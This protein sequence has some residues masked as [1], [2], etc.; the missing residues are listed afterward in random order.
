M[1]LHTGCRIDPAVDFVLAQIVT[2]MGKRTIR[3]IEVLVARLDL[4]LVGMAVGTE[5]F[6]M[7]GGTGS[8][9]AGINLVFEHEVRGLVIKGAPR[10]GMALGTVRQTFNRFGVNPGDAGGVGASKEHT[11]CQ[12]HQD[13]Q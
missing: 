7:T 12:R 8:L 10:V 11:G 2:T 6:L 13:S 3:R 4:L 9:R 1:A 5:G